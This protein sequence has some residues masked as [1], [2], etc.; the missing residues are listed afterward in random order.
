MQIFQKVKEK[1]MKSENITDAMMKYKQTG[2]G[3]EDLV[4]KIGILVYSM[5]KDKYKMNEDDRGDF[6]CMFYKKIPNL[7][8]RFEYYGTPFEAYLNVSIRWNIKSFRIS[9]S[10]YRSIQK[11]ILK[12][13]FYLIPHE[14]DFTKII[15]TDLHISETA[16]EVLRLEGTKEILSDTIRKRLLYIYL[17]ESDHIDERIKEGI[18]RITGYKRK[19]LETC[20]EK[21]K[22][23]VERRLNRI[24]LIKTRRNTAFLEFHILQEKCSFAE[25]NNEK[26]ELKDQIN[27]LRKRIDQMNKD[28]SKAIVRPTHK[29][30]ADILQI[31]KGSIDSGIYYIKNSFKEMENIEKK[32]A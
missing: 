23:K 27:K 11:A 1:S 21:L 29:D 10:K 15:K 13:P 32:T 18:I 8:K 22:E 19:W 25:N 9:K 17:I 14:N 7:I 30:I 5:M 16:R 6:F 31:P 28:I 24:K 4:K 3:Y 20:S 26:E 2:I 12:K